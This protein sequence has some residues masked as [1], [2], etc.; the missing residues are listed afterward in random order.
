MFNIED[1]REYLSRDG[2]AT[3]G[4]LLGVDGVTLLST[5]VVTLSNE[6]SIVRGS[7]LSSR[8]LGHLNS[9]A[10]T[11]TLECDGSDEALDLGGLPLAETTLLGGNLTV[12]DKLA[13][14]IILGQVE[15][16]ADLAGT[17][18]TETAGNGRVGEPGDGS[19]TGL[20]DDEGEGSNISSN[21]AATDRLAA[22]LTITTGT[23]A[24]VT[25]RQEQAGTA[26]K[27]NTLLHGETL[28]VVTTGNLQ[29]VTLP[30][31]TEGISLNL[32]SHTLI[33]KDA[34]IKEKIRISTSYI[35]GA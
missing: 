25:S 28:L 31:I 29:D 10:M 14:I 7:L 4:N 1:Y 24:G 20:G 11:L 2:G 15:E 9:E 30:L 32:L 6:L 35:Q 5:L 18:G 34:A 17:L 16:L 12:D 21:N 3:S 26:S 13:D 33:V 27:E 23:V 8:S 19:L 22:T